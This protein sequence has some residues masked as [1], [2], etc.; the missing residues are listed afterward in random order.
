MCTQAAKTGSLCCVAARPHGPSENAHNWPNVGDKPRWHTNEGFAAPHASSHLGHSQSDDYLGTSSRTVPTPRRSLSSNSRGSRSWRR[1]DGGRHYNHFRTPSG[2]LYGGSPNNFIW[3][4]L[5]SSSHRTAGSMTTES[6]I[7]ASPS[8]SIPS[9][10]AEQFF[11]RPRAFSNKLESTSLPCDNAPKPLSTHPDSKFSS[12]SHVDDSFLSKPSFLVPENP[13][14]REHYE[15]RFLP[16]GPSRVPSLDGRFSFNRSSSSRSSS[17]GGSS[18]DWS[19]F[20]G[21]MEVGPDARQEW[22]RMA[23]VTSQNDCGWNLSRESY[24]RSF[25]HVYMEK[26]TAG[27]SQLALP[28]PRSEICGVCSR[29]LAQRSPWASSRVMGFHECNVIGVL[30]CGHTYHTECLEQITPESA[31][32]D[33]ACPRCN[34]DKGMPK[35]SM[36]SMSTQL[37]PRSVRG[38]SFMSRPSPRN[39]LS[40]VGVMDDNIGSEKPKF[41]ISSSEEPS[42]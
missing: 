40:R 26:I 21:F 9:S 20:H 19:T 14:R 6:E 31:R 12:S 28:S 36:I 7:A 18:S 41:L 10:K 16:A 39:K 42:P 8:T 1:V 29:T 17:P 33:P 27:G 3:N 32:Q 37:K 15:G 23:N 25:G 22:L 34:S 4:P 5:A 2:S 35:N 11:T 38:N 30:V 24:D 13:A